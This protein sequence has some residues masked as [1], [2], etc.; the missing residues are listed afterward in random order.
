M[1]ELLIVALET[2]GMLLVSFGLGLVAAWWFG[3]AGLTTISGVCVLGF[4]TLAAARQRAMST[5]PKQP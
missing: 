4:A 3:M 5:P 1:Q 2:L